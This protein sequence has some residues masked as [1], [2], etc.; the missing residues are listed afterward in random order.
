MN[1]LALT[2]LC[3]GFAA[4]GCLPQDSARVT[5][6][7]QPSAR[8]ADPAPPAPADGNRP[9]VLRPAR[10]FDAVAA[11]PHE[12]WVV[13]VRGEKI[14]AAG[15]AGEVKPPDG[16]RT[17]DLPKMTLLPG[18]ID[19]HTHVLLHPYNEADWN[20]QV[21]REPYALRVCRATNHLRS[22]LQSGFT[23][24]RDLGTEGAGYADVGLKQAVEEKIVP[25]PRMLVV[26]RAIVATRS[27]APR[28][29]APE[30]SVPQGAEE[31]DGEALRRV[32]RDQIGRGADWIKVYT[33]SWDPKKGGWPT[34]SEDEFKLIVETARS[35]H[36][37]VC[38]H[39]MT[40]EGLRRAVAGGVETIE[41]GWGG[42]IE[43]FRLMVNRGVALCPTL[44]TAEAN[45]KYK[46][47]KPGTSPEPAE[48]KSAR[49]AFQ[50]ALEAGV[51]VVNGSDIGVFPHGEG[52]REI[53]LLVQF[54]MKPPAAMHAATSGAAKVLHLDDRLGSIK[55]GLLADL[56]AVEG[57]PT[58][59][60]TALRKVRL[61]MKGGTLYREP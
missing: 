5:P 48:F 27:Y 22:L 60:V 52:A 59:D 49:V 23:T 35:A 31:A 30:V 37:P 15:P 12:G 43:V 25:G 24:I 42:D 34:F 32:V 56:I 16:A 21:L 53:E 58:S 14:E 18:L 41:H 8:P 50:Q 28:G 2:V 3:L 26:T 17:I 55:P 1:R 36:V 13:V 19:A 6:A 45:S 4:V 20:D 47:W 10:V 54:G 40:K 57:D 7:E 39:A 29:F 9:I 44:A 61:V 11:Q 33:D 38:A 51:T 46:G